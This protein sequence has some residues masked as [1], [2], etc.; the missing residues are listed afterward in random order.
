MTPTS[1]SS[2]RARLT[3]TPVVSLR[4][5]GSSPVFA[6]ESKTMRI[7]RISLALALLSLPAAAEL[8]RLDIATRTPVLNNKPF[9][10]AGPY[11]KLS[12]KA[13]YSLDPAA[14]PN[15]AIVDLD[16]APR[17]SSGHVLFS[18]DVMI[19]RPVDPA[20]SNGV[21]LFEVVNRGNKSLLGRFNHGTAAAD[22]VTEADFG[23]GFL[24]RQGYTLIFLGWQFDV[25]RRPGVMGLDAPPFP[26]FGSVST[27]FTPNAASN[28][29]ELNTDG[30]YTTRMYKPADPASLANTLTVRDGLLGT[31]HV[32]ARADWRI[33]DS[34]V[35]L[36][37]GFEPGRTYQLT[38]NVTSS[39][40]AGVAF[41]AFRDF[42]AY[43]K[44]APA[45]SPVA[46]RYAYVFGASQDGRFLRDFLYQ[47]FNADE[48]GA[49]AFD[50]V[51]AH[52]AGASRGDFNVRF[53]SPNGLGAFT[54]TR[55]P[56]LDSPQF[57]P[58]SGRT[59]GLLSHL[60]PETTPRI[61]YTNS[62][63]EYWGGGRS[64]ALTHTTLDGK[65]DAVLPDNVR[66]YLFAGTQ[67]GPAL[68][69]TANRLVQNDANPNDYAWGQ[70]ALLNALDRWVRDGIAPPPARYPHLAD[71]SLVPQKSL[72]FP[73][74][75]GVQSPLRI[76]GG[77]RSDLE[78]GPAAH[79]LPYLVPK[80]DADGNELGGIRF[81]ET[82][83]P[84]ATYTGWN[85][86]NPSIGAP[87]EIY[88]LIGTYLPF[89]LT[90]EAREKTHD[91][92]LSVAERYPSRDAYLKQVTDTV[93]K[94]AAEGYVLRDDVPAIV[95]Q[96]SARWD[97]VT[98]PAERSAK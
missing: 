37:A 69:G 77:Y 75:P 12:G 95:A 89:A 1:P 82:A 29:Y 38:Y 73:A 13:F 6:I 55:F 84:L 25:P 26:V 18:A 53:A 81:P 87:G 83:V 92:R 60:T 24:L 14:A 44:H 27:T 8:A 23:D 10:A 34:A 39:Y 48:H 15:K 35:S 91:P 17:D 32:I 41:A 31:P 52:I 85:F 46:A 22:P 49:R 65:E 7:L 63:T 90:R 30:Y 2:P 28:T 97:T 64:A 79:P 94:L 16:K 93:T 4:D 59:E 50:G 68:A 57:D 5:P 76:P 47:G 58:V 42:A 56:Y 61:I 21:A 33:N 98:R 40:V 51:T 45:A 67:H 62:S 20:H 43:V 19:L 88:P 36:P 78:G 9:G 96:A 80:V 86:R 66:I 72:D 11:E 3:A 71:G 74:L 70:R 54:V